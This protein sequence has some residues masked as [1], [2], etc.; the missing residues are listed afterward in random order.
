MDN[1][2]A[3]RLAN[4]AAEAVK[5][6]DSAR[7]AELYTSALELVEPKPATDGGED[8]EVDGDAYKIRMGVLL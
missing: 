6:G 3:K 1:L 5:G 4:A 8:R 2:K 7:A